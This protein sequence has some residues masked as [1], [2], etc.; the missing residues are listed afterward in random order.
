M[1]YCSESLDDRF[2]HCIID[3][4]SVTTRKEDIANLRSACYIVDSCLYAFRWRLAVVLTG[5][6]AA[7]AVAAVHRAHVGDEEQN[8]VGVTVGKSR[9]WRILVLVKRVEQIGCRLVKFSGGRYSLLADR[10][11]RV[12]GVNE[13]QVVRSDSHTEGLQ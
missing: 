6:S 3:H 7:C 1:R 13:A 2:E 11:V 9:N 8:S 12:V 5:E 10:V 4:K